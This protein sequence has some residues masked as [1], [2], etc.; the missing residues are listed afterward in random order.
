MGDKSAHAPE[1]TSKV[2]RVQ[3]A[4]P[5]GLLQP[6]PRAPRNCTPVTMV[7]Q[8]VPA[9]TGMPESLSPSRLDLTS[10]EIMVHESDS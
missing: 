10:N 2:V 5:R 9:C 1:P 7:H 3:P 6:C 4:H 8:Q